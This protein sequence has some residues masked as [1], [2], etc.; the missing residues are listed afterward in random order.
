MSWKHATIGL[1]V[2]SSWLLW[3]DCHRPTVKP[4]K[5]RAHEQRD[6]DSS[7][8]SSSSSSRSLA[9]ETE[10]PRE[11]AEPASG[12][13][14]GVT[15]RGFH[16]PGWAMRLTPQSGESLLAYR[17]RIVPLAQTAIAPHRARVARGRED[18]A[19][20]AHLDSRQKAELDAAVSDAAS[21]IEEKLLSAA[22]GGDFS[23]S[24]FKPMTGIVLARDVLD[25]VDRAN[26]RFLRSLDDGQ[27]ALLAQHPFDLADYLV[28]ST[29]W[30]DALGYSGR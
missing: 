8:S 3:R 27:R 23:P 2:L 14:D 22:L 17:D 5:E 7:A 25:V 16:V 10:T 28:F 21:Q 12:G 6:E 18:F 1:A 11:T 24:T 13:K 30:E 9:S 15:I 20:A 26:Q 4:E 19:T 29:R